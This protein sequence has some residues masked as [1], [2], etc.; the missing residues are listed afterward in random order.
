MKSKIFKI[1]GVALALVLAFSLGASFLP[2]NTASE[3]EAGDLTWTN[4]SE[5]TGTGQVLV[6]DD[7]DVGPVVIS[8]NFASDNTMFALVSDTTGT[9]R[10]NVYASTNGGHTWTA[11]TSN[12]GNAGDLGIALEISP[13]FATDSTVFAVTQDMNPPIAASS[14]AVYRSTN[15]GSTFGQLGVVTMAANEVITSF[16]VSPDYDGT[17][18]LAVG[19]A[20]INPGAVVATA[21][22]CVQ[23]WGLGGVLS[24]TLYG[25]V[26]YDVSAV[27]FSPNY[28]IDTTILTVSQAANAVPM[29]RDIVGGTWNQIA[30]AGVNI[31]ATAV[32]VDL[33]RLRSTPATTTG[34]ISA[35]IA[36][37]Q[38]YNGTVAT[39]RRAYIAIV[40][41]AGATLLGTSGNVYRITNVT[42]GTAIATSTLNSA[43]LQL[44][45]LDYSGTF[46]EG[47]LMGGVWSDT[48]A[49]Q[50]DVY[51]TTNPTDSTVNWYG[52]AGVENQPSG[53]SVA[54]ALSGDNTT[55]WVYMS[56]DY[57]N[58]STVA[59]G[60]FGDES[61]FGVS[62]DGAVSFNETGLID[63]GAG[64]LTLDT[65][66]GLALSPD[67][68]ND[69]VVYW[70]TED[71]AAN[72]NGMV[73]KRDGNFWTRCFYTTLLTAAGTGVCACS[74]EYANDQTAYV[75]D[76]GGTDV[77]YTANA[78]N[79]W[80]RRTCN[81]NVQSIAAPDATT[82]YVGENAGG[83]TRVA[84]STNSGWTFPAALRKST[85]NTGLI[86]DLKVSGSTVL[87]GGS[88]GSVRR[89]DDGGST[90]ALVG[91]G[92]LP[93]LAATYV[94]F[95]DDY[96]WAGD[97]GAAAGA[98]HIYRSDS[99][100]A[101]YALNE[102]ATATN[103]AYDI[104]AV[105]GLALAA[106]GTLYLGDPTAAAV[107]AGAPY[108]SPVWRSI[109]PEATEPTPGLTIEAIPGLGSAL[110]VGISLN[111]VGGD[112]NVVGI[113]DTV[114]DR[115]SVYTDTMSKS[116]VTVPE[117]VSPADG[118]IITSGTAGG[119]INVNFVVSYA[120]QVT[121]VQVRYANNADFSNPANS[122]VVA[123]ATATGAVDLAA[124]GF[125][126][127]TVYWK[128]RA[129]A[130]FLS[131]W[132]DYRTIELPVI[133]AVQAPTPMSPGSSAGSTVDVP[134]SPVLN[135]SAFKLANG[136][137]MQLAKDADMTDFIADM[138]GAN[139]LGNVTSWKCTST[140]AYSTTYFWRVRAIIGTSATY[141][142]WSNTVGFT[143][144]AK[145]VEPTPPVIIEP[146]PAPTPLPTP[147]TP[148]YI[149]AIIAIG[150]VL[151]IVVIVLIVRTRRP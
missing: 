40:A 96:V 72:G 113:I 4:Y 69:G 84:K 111:V 59:V 146:T 102:P 7:L 103:D 44:S 89:S 79:T 87:A 131:G 11:S 150:A 97:G 81:M 22:S 47:T 139:A 119:T 110:S 78:G 143:T 53:V 99:G 60:T 109:A 116:S 114:N 106:D 130:P 142:D 51:R 14:G 125:E 55:T 91:G 48:A 20:N 94:A 19:I 8:P 35:D 98:A 140:L 30:A 41:E 42:Q 71:D 24:W 117:L 68:V 1:T 5:P 26:A 149:Y 31:G 144:M 126:G 25:G 138:T 45:N 65:H 33:D 32:T 147:T 63:N 121:T 3:A 67:F 34:L 43:G 92:V 62:T 85:G 90:W 54:A 46:A 64:P 27:K 74:A 61:A 128:A 18:V 95:D 135:W 52:V 107:V 57:T 10:P 73:W 75:G 129:T 23:V 50:C 70:V 13:S 66:T 82:V 132:S 93:G 58:D 17:G 122:N 80:S 134:I 9:L 2:V 115:V 49:T 108:K 29:L 120:S 28:S 38:D 88:T 21:T 39:L 83:A 124:L 6:D 118:A 137:E 148:A 76:V 15:G 12:L 86:V 56:K 123:P 100:G 127:Q 36:L 77:W 16:D 151:V 105:N 133:T 101:W 104:D 112:S 141:S 37:P 145:P 136:Y